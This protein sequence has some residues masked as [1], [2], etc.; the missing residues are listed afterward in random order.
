MIFDKQNNMGC[1]IKMHPLFPAVMDYVESYLR[2]PVAPGI[3]EI[4]GK[5]LFVK[6][7]DYETRE[8][9]FLEV[10]DQYIDVQCMIEG[11]EKVYYTQRDG[12]IPACEYDA[13]EDA[14]FLKDKEGCLEF[15]FRAGE[16][17]VFFPQDAHK[18]AM[19]I[20]TKEKAKKLVFKVRIQETE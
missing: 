6:V 17:A 2:N 10:H 1:Y 7:Q 14:L 11:I 13:Q 20:G 3:Y 4:S 15:L 18:P 16:F 12:L 19:S 8:E 9:G 5:D